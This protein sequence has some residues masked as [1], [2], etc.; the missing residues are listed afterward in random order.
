MSEAPSRVFKVD[1][2]LFV[3]EDNSYIQTGTEAKH[4]KDATPCYKF[5]LAQ[6]LRKYFFFIEGLSSDDQPMNPDSMKRA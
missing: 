3:F 1:Q 6:R 4:F 2:E 5:N